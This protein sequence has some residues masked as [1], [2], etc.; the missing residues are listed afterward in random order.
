MSSTQHPTPEGPPRRVHRIAEVLLW[1]LLL[2]AT[3]AAYI[4]W[5]GTQQRPSSRCA[6]NLKQIGLGF[7]LYQQKNQDRLPDADG[8]AFL[9][10]IFTGGYLRDPAVYL[11]PSCPYQ[12]ATGPNLTAETC[13]FAGRRNRTFPLTSGLIAKYG[14]RTVLAAD[15]TLAHHLDV[16]RVLFADGHVEEVALEDFADYAEVLGDLH[17]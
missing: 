15:R 7:A 3:C 11:C 8:I 16:Y 13:S 5:V 2:A 10:A 1:L 9:D 6:A 4:G 12:K 17:D 14:S